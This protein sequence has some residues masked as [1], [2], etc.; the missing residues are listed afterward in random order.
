M[1]G[2]PYQQPTFLLDSIFLPNTPMKVSSLFEGGEMGTSSF[3][4][5]PSETLQEFPVVRIHE[6]CNTTMY[7]PS[8]HEPTVTETNKTD[9]CTMAVEVEV[10]NQ[11]NYKE[12]PSEN[13]R[14]ERDGSC[15]SS[16]QFQPVKEA[17]AKKTNKCSK[18]QREVDKKNQKEVSQ[19]PPIHVRARRGEATDSHS[20][21]E[22]VRREKISVRMKLLQGLIPGRDKVL[23]TAHMLDEIINYV[24]SLQYQVEFLSM[25]LTSINPMLSQFGADFNTF[26]VKSEKPNTLASTLP[27]M[28]LS[29]STQPVALGDT[30][31]AFNTRSNYS[32]QD[33]ENLLWDM[34]KQRQMFINQ[35]GFNNL[36]S[37][38]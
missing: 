20:L 34:D 35:C 32:I 21:A 31:T 10:G 5:Y 17:K 4:F 23:G 16:A 27:P 19:E 24:Q 18:K 8:D 7:L 11:V 15:L 33:N 1:A 13:K 22:R 3:P 25:K 9:S 36:C 12:N 28:Q 37:F 6:N 38:Q 30:T 14:K 2:F 26:E 29:S